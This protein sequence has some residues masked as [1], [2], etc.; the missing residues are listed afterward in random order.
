V[1]A[2]VR[3][4]TFDNAL[5]V[6]QSVSSLWFKECMKPEHVMPPY[7]EALSLELMEIG[8]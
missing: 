1:I 2:K 8:A 4:L 3:E 6:S 7:A 5:H